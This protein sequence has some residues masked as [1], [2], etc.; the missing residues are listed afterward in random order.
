MSGSSD[1]MVRVWNWS[2]KQCVFTL[3]QPQNWVRQI[4]L[5]YLRRFPIVRF[6]LMENILCTEGLLLLP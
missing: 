5:S 6:F 2:T 1:G 3:S 4:I